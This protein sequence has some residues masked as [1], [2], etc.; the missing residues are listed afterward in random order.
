METL[1][2]EKE[3]FAWLLGE[4]LELGVEEPKIAAAINEQLTHMELNS[5]DIDSIRRIR[6][7]AIRH[8][9]EKIIEVGGGIGRLSAWLLDAFS[10]RS[11]L[12]EYTIVEAG[13]KFAAIILR[14]TQRFE[15]SD[16]T[17]VSGM[18]FQELAGVCNAWLISNKALLNSASLEATNS[19][20]AIPA[21]L[22]I[23]DVGEEEQVECITVHYLYCQR[24]DYC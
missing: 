23:I 24:M 13:N 22:I 10:S 17:H 7:I 15:A 19:P 5:L 2:T 12:P 14:L 18:R 6:D 3:A 16:W 20:A 8:N 11:S 1:P 21:D 4:D 9:P